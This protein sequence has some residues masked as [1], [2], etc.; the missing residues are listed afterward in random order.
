MRIVL[1][2]VLESSV[3]VDG[4][5]IGEI[6]P[7]LLAL[8]GIAPAD[9]ERLL[10]P[11][12]EKLVHLRIFEDQEGKMSRSLLDTAGQ[13]LLVSQFTLYA[14]CKKGRRPSFTSAA[15]P[16][17]AEALYQRFIEI[18]ADLTGRPPACGQF[19]ADMKISLI[20]DGPVT[21]LLDSNEL[22]LS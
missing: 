18:C 9:T 22:G 4:K 20:N 11:M 14:D 19:G 16:E 17:Q 5:G 21:I 6:G 1:Q 8:V 10:L 2:R 7:G 13:L 3:K 12:A 15:P